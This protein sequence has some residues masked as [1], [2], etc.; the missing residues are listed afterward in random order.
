[1]TYIVGYNA[2]KLKTRWYISNFE[3]AM[4][5]LTR[6]RSKAFQFDTSERDSAMMK[7]V[8]MMR[9]YDWTVEEIK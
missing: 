2:T 6:N 4:Q 1:M 5:N 9:P 8:K 3:H 7:R